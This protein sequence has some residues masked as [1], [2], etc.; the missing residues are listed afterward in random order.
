VLI[1]V[2]LYLLTRGEGLVEA[3]D[4]VLAPA[5]AEVAT[6]SQARIS[7]ARLGSLGIAAALVTALCWAAGT[8]TLALAL[9][10]E[11]NLL[12][13]T[14]IRVLLAGLLLLPILYWIRRGRPWQNYTRAA[15]PALIGLAL[16]VS[17]L[18]NLFFAWAVEYAGAAR[19]ALLITASPL[20]GVPLSAIFLKERIT[21]R[22]WVGT[23]LTV[24]GVWLVLI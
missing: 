15:M 8:T 9:K 4:Y 10:E 3:N 2:A 23:L 12:G 24:L 6:V 14:T 11:P 19:A 1:L 16:F 20:I 22:V 5:S 7:R 13:I 17:V 21:R 18:G